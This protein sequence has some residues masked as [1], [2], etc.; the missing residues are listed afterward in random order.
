MAVL[1][2]HHLQRRL[3]NPV[4]LIQPI[5]QGRRGFPFTDDV[6]SIQSRR[7][8]QVR[9][10][11]NEAFVKSLERSYLSETSS[12]LMEYEGNE[13]GST[14]SMAGPSFE[15]L[16]RGIAGMWIARTCVT[17]TAIDWL[18]ANN[19]SSVGKG[20]NSGKQFMTHKSVQTLLNSVEVGK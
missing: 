15:G 10:L 20:L 19:A 3:S 17:K 9:G 4:Y 5:A 6:H 18:E 12:S 8:A 1:S 7:V 14:H 2:S 13:D 11:Q 16:D